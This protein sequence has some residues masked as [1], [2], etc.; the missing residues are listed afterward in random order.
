MRPGSQSLPYSFVRFVCSDQED[1]G[2]RLRF[3]NSQGGFDSIKPRHVQI[4]N[5]NLR[6]NGFGLFYSFSAAG[7]LN[8]FPSRLGFQHRADAATKEVV[9]ICNQDFYLR[10]VLL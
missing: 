8:D 4:K 7:D 5:C 2:P 10:H 9:I 1:L 6:V 3:A